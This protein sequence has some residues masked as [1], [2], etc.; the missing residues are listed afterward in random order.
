MSPL[1]EC[2]ES[3]IFEEEFPEGALVTALFPTRAGNLTF[4]FGLAPGFS[5]ST[6]SEIL[7]SVGREK[8]G[9]EGKYALNNFGGGE[10]ERLSLV[11]EKMM[12]IGDDGELEIMR[13]DGDKGGCGTCGKQTLG[14]EDDCTFDFCRTGGSRTSNARTDVLDFAN[15]FLDAF[16]T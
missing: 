9:G 8:S 6:G 14:E 2:V 4:T 13:F 16:G 10:G 3:S 5:T 15:D 11:A 7:D 12:S 1:R